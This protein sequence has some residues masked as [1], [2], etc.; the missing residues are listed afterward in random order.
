MGDSFPKSTRQSQ[1]PGHTSAEGGRRVESVASQSCGPDVNH[2]NLPAR[3][4]RQGAFQ[5]RNPFDFGKE[6]PMAPPITE[7]YLQKAN[8]LQLFLV[9]RKWMKYPDNSIKA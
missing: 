1:L 5:A 2:S 3:L 7:R 4:R 6:S 8:V 9:G